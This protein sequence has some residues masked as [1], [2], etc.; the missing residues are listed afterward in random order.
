MLQHNS[1]Y[2]KIFYLCYFHSILLVRHPHIQSPHHL[3]NLFCFHV[4]SIWTPCHR[5]GSKDKYLVPAPSLFLVFDNEYKIFISVATST[6]YSC[7]VIPT[8]TSPFPKSF[9]LQRILHLNSKFGSVKHWRQT[10]LPDP[11]FSHVSFQIC[12]NTF[13]VEG[14][15]K[16]MYC[17][18]SMNF[19]HP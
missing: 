16:T 14:N 5:H 1:G 7:S 17:I 4:Y 8:V 9:L 18:I 15:K 19:F 10:T 6:S 3:S 12:F 2:N 11:S 13:A